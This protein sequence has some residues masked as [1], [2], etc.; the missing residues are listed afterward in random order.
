MTL[1][2][3]LEGCHQN[4]IEA[5]KTQEDQRQIFSDRPVEPQPIIA[6]LKLS[7]PALIESARLEEG[8]W[9]IEKE[10]LEA[11]KTE[12]EGVIGKLK[13]LS[14]KIQ[15]LAR[16]RMIF[17]GLAISAPADI[18]EALKKIP[19]I[20]IIQNSAIFKRPQ[21]SKT[22]LENSDEDKPFD[23]TSMDFIGATRVHRL[24]KDGKGRA[25]LGQDLR[26]GVIDTGIDFTHKML[27]GVGSNEAYKSVNPSEPSSFFP[28]SKVIGGTDFVGSNFDAASEKFEAQV[29]APD[30]NPLDEAGH[31]SHV[32][33]TIAG[34]GDGIQT[35][36]GV[37]PEAKLYA[38]K[39]FGRDGSTSD[40]VVTEALEYAADPNQDGDP[41][42]HL[43]VVN[44]SLG[45]AYGGPLS[46]YSEAVR[47][48]SRTGAVVVASA[49]NS[50]PSDYIVGSPSTA[51]EA[52]SI[53]AS[54]DDMPQNWKFGASKIYSTFHPEVIVKAVEGT[55]AKPIHEAGPVSGD[56]V[57]IGLAKKPLADEL[58]MKVKGHVALID[59]GVVTFAE[60]LKEAA[61]A[62]A[63]GAVVINN[64]PG[65]AFSMGGG[66]EPVGIPAIMVTKE[67]GDLVK[68]DLVKGEVR[69]DFS[70]ATQ[71]E[72]P[73]RID[74]ITDF[75]SKGPR[76]ED[77]LLK[78]E[79][80]APGENV[81]SAA[82]GEGDRGVQMSGTSMAGP[83]MAGVVGLLRQIHPELSPVEIK[84]L[85]MSTAKALS[86]EKIGR[87]PLSL[88][89]AGRVQT[90]LAA[91]A[92][93]ALTPASIS[94]G[95]IQVAT[96]KSLRRTLTIKNLANEAVTLNL[97]AESR[98][99]GIRVS[100]PTQLNL[101]PKASQNVTVLVSLDGR[102]IK[103][104]TE[105]LEAEIQIQSSKADAPLQRVPLLAVASQLSRIKADGV[106]VMAASDEESA[107]AAATVKLRNDGEF[108]GLAYLFNLIGY[109]SRKS[110]PLGS[111][112]FRSRSCDLESA[113]Y[114]II[115][116][117]VDGQNRL[118]L[119]FALKLF[120]PLTTW[121]SCELSIQI[122]SNDDGEADQE[123]AGMVMNNLAGLTA[124]RF[125]SVL[126]DAKAARILRLQYEQ[127]Q[128]KGEEASLSYASAVLD[129]QELKTFD[130]STLAIV[131]TPLEKIQLRGN[132]HLA[133]KIA[134]LSQDSD[135][136][137]PD[138][139]M[140][141]AFANW[142]EL[143]SSQST[144]AFYDMPGEV[145]V[146][147]HGQID[148]GITKGAG[149]RP[150]LV[151][152]PLNSVVLAV[153]GSLQ[154]DELR[155]IYAESAK[156][157]P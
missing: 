58:K 142:K 98:N 107:G 154:S 4:S 81:I 78:P 55:A 101:A 87:Y 42:D 106:Y 115:E 135:S 71:I 69:I 84:S 62:G 85:A 109:D 29:P 118:M 114:R 143:E 49:G 100:I 48:L 83:H 8:K 111:K 152:M 137:Q 24:I 93:L 16:Y 70:T 10:H 104:K 35:Y 105:E 99:A 68:G 59:R 63:I 74:T 61:D 96:S 40:F 119:Q 95:E 126:L 133:V 124:Q 2:M 36:D 41:N 56:F 54:V 26:I 52:F 90:Y 155:P 112:S 12:Q 139:V 9:Q 132:G 72:E 89:G 37:A 102:Q 103:Q 66:E 131:E 136:I 44:L 147:P 149:H 18:R 13:A 60:K 45:G 17:N 25:V 47:N 22:S 3:G 46:L 15:I 79:I 110:V 77:S 134:S 148:V 67:V 32:A 129:V 5:L 31:G 11:V 150:L 27:G 64:Q 7:E 73:W 86:G 141:G 108:P 88:Q 156:T 145:M 116:K 51:D 43:D 1:V 97:T 113:G 82:M 138:D 20:R 33:G 123:L 53:A 151:Y 34:R 14:P 122:D 57:Y 144:Q 6:T 153:E 28:N 94:L 39:V 130:H 23:H 120:E 128:A 127:R 19:E 140:G 80:S 38:L 117:F 125:A 75:S 21:S 65:D 146:P 30:S 121:N 91:T 76:S 157:K 50:G 92:S